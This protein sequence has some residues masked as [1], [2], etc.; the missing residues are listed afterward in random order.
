MKMNIDES[1]INI[2]RPRNWG[3]LFLGVFMHIALKLLAVTLML[4]I[5]ATGTLA[6]QMTHVYMSVTWTFGTKPETHRV[7]LADAVDMS[8]LAPLPVR[9]RK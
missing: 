5:I 9:G 1:L 7:A 3:R 8:K 4:A 6:V 2:I